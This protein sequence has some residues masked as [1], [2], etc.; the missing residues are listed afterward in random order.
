DIALL[1]RPAGAASGGH[2]I[3]VIEVKRTM[4]D[5]RTG[6]QQAKEYGKRL[7]LPMVYATNGHKII[8]IDLAAGTQHAVARFKT[9][10][11]LWDKS[12]RSTR[13][14]LPWSTWNFC[15]CMWCSS[16]R[17]TR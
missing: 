15:A 17:S 6:V 8:E 5:E 3:S 12:P 13:C 10:Q 9:P 14:Q 2:P 11:Q 16:R 4:R 1:H 7:D